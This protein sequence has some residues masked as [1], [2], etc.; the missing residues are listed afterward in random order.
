MPPSS[1]KTI[2]AAQENFMPTLRELA[3]AYQAFSNYSARH[4]RSVGLTPPQFDVISTLGNTD[5]MS[6]N[7]LGEKTLI[8]KG[9][10]TGI[11]DRLEEKGLVKRAVTEGNRRSFT[12][13]LTPEGEQLFEQ[14]FPA[15]VAHLKARFMGLS[16]AQLDQLFV[17]LKMLRTL[18]E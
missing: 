1:S 18:F 3:G 14:I 13:A 15:H 10:L 8:T 9:T 2:R 5:G 6:M 11:I 4:V 7:K 17:A 16:E 12:V